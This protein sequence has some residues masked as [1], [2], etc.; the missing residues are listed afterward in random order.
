M[1]DFKRFIEEENHKAEQKFEFDPVKRIQWFNSQVADLYNKIDNEWL[2]EYISYGGIITDIKP[3][4][5][6]EEALGEYDSL[7]KC[8]KIG[9]NILNIV[10]VGTIILGTKARIDMTFHG[11][12]VMMVLVGEKIE[13]ASQMIDIYINSRPSRKRQDPGKP[14]WKF[15]SHDK[16]T[17]LVEITTFSFQKQIMDLMKDS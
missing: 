17:E 10:P 13:Y 12:S 11:K 2:K 14:V 7:A 5:I 3:I 8:I 16:L 9:N 15:A 6:F 4:K 1:T